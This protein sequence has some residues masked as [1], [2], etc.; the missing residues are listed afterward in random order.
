MKG[1]L[2]GPR[3][4]QGFHLH[5]RHLGLYRH[6][7]VGNV[8]CLP[9][10]GI[11]YPTLERPGWAET[12]GQSGYVGPRGGPTLPEPCSQSQQRVG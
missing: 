12:W 4:E 9:A 6:E 1:G 8:E 5:W 10:Q 11:M 7:I 3:L 2:W